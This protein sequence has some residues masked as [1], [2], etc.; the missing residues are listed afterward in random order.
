[1][2][3]C[4]IILICVDMRGIYL[5]FLLQRIIVPEHNFFKINKNVDDY[6]NIYIN[7]QSWI[8]YYNYNKNSMP[9]HFDNTG[10]E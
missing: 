4:K 5:F 3:G 10:Y 6:Y 8:N 7:W 2:N 1:M 9:Y